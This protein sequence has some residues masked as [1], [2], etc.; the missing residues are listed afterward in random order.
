MKLNLDYAEKKYV[1]VAKALGVYRADASDRENGINAIERV[2]RL[3]V[4]IGAPVSL[5]PYITEKPD[6]EEI[7]DIVRRTTG[8]I[9]CN[10]R[11]LDQQLMV[12][13][14]EGAMEES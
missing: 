12:E 13:A 3:R 10:P 5:K 4:E 11:P 9:T 8:H 14:F 2:K 1:N 6:I 7:L